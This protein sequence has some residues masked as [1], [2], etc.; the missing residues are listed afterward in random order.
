MG[1]R[2]PL[3][4]ESLG[5][6]E[7]PVAFRWPR[8]RFVEESQCLGARILLSQANRQFRGEICHRHFISSIFQLFQTAPQ[9]LYPL[10]YTR[11]ANEV[12]PSESLGNGAVGL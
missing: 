2:E 6:L 4:Q 3:T 11:E 8:F 1:E 7:S 12:A 9:K 10:W 5:Y